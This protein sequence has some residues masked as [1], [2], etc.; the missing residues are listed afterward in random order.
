MMPTRDRDVSDAGAFR[1]RHPFARVEL[2]GIER[3]REPL[4]AVDGHAAILHHPFALGQL[5]VHA[6][7]DE[8]P[9]LRV[10]KPCARR[11]A[12]GRLE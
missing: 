7:V 10:T 8:E 2:Y 5:A 11:G 6:P 1:E 3:R 9:E 12:F 4:V